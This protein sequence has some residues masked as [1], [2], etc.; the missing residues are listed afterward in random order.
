MVGREGSPERL[1]EEP[2]GAS[3]P[4]APKIP[5]SPPTSSVNRVVIVD[6]PGLPIDAEVRGKQAYHLLSVPALIRYARLDAD[7]LDLPQTFREGDPESAWLRRELP[8]WVDGRL[9]SADDSV[10]TAAQALARRLGRNLGYLLA[11]LH[12]GDEVNRAARSDWSA[13]EWQHWQRVQRV[14]LGG[15]VVSGDLGDKMVHHARTVLEETGCAIAIDKT[16]YPRHMATLGAGRFMPRPAEPETCQR[17]LVLDFGQTSVKRAILT[18]RGNDLV[19]ADQLATQ[20]VVWRWRNSPVAALDLDP[21]EVL[22]LVAGTLCESL[23]LSERVGLPVGPDVV[24]SIA[25]YVR[26]G[27]LL[28]NGG[29]A[30]MR[31]LAEDVRPLIADRVSATCGRRIR[32]AIV[33]DGTAAAAV[34]AGEMADGAESAVIVVGTALGVG[35]PPASAEGLRGLAP[36]LAIGKVEPGND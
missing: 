26:G 33:H 6:L 21:H 20:P 29:Y 24:V 10:R 36:D 22:D 1:V 35:F 18:Y 4:R 5:Y 12:R 30:R 11:T 3:D 27:E 25:A 9:S 14:W 23:A 8:L 2:G 7:A 32:I 31:Q 19:R 28:G 34:H 17:G 15:G 16:P 13:T